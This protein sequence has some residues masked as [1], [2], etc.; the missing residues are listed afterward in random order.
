MMAEARR[1]VPRW[2]T[3]LGAGLLVCV[4]CAAE[5]PLERVT[6]G[7]DIVLPP[8]TTTIR[9]LIAPRTTL[10]SLL[11]EVGLPADAAAG[12]V[13]AA[14]AVFDP[15]RLRTSQPFLVEQTYDGRLRRFRYEIDD[16][17]YL[18]VVSAGDDELRAEILS[19]PRTLE[20][21]VMAGEIDGDAPSLFSAMSRAGGGAELS[22]ALARIFAGEIDFTSDVRTGD[23][24]VFTYER[25]VREDGPVSYGAITAAEFQNE[26][27][28]LRAIYFTPPGGKPDYFD[29]EGRSL[30]RF[31]LRSPL[32]FDPRITSRYSSRRLHPVL[33]TARAHRGVDYGAPSG[34]P[35]VA[36][37]AGTV[38]SASFD[39]AN[40]R[41]VRLR[42]ASG[43]ES[44]YLHLSAFAP[45]ITRGARVDQ[46]QMIGRVGATGLATGPHLHYGLRKNGAWVDPLREHRNMPPG[47]P[48]PP[49]AMSAFRAVRDAALAQLDEALPDDVE[50]FA[51]AEAR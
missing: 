43:Y 22:I 44:Y 16:D 45:A 11:Q 6:A 8:D 36:V 21:D 28:R 18:R 30:R 14:R 33:R 48:V 23:R 5:P 25:F 3:W 10:Q 7:R 38:V 39:R 34:A 41:M 24:F 4:G 47:E 12:V 31:F 2:R 40:G 46:G 9:G 26:G 32:R 13:D 35:V 42:H 15:R 49:H 19:I 29:E 37:A 50:L 51:S 17:S 27:R 20:H 1:T